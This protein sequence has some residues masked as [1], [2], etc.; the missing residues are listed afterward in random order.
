MSMESMSVKPAQVTALSGE[1]RSGA[2]NI[3][4]E[5]DRLETAVGR[6]RSAWGG[7]AQVAYDAA[8][9]KWT[10][11]VTQMQELLG[12]IATKTEQISGQYVQ[13]DRSSAGRFGA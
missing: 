3:R 12:Q 6:L 9:R 8:Q 1:I 11:S 10:N 5:L 7:E 13:S 4:A 2:Q